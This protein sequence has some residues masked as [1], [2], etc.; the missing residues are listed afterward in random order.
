MYIYGGDGN[1][2]ALGTL[3]ELYPA[4]KWNN[5]IVNTPFSNIDFT[6]IKIYANLAKINNT[7]YVVLPDGTLKTVP[8]G[9]IA[10]SARIM[11]LDGDMTKTLRIDSA[12]IQFIRFDNGTIFQ[13]NANEI[14]PISSLAKY[15]SLGGNSTNTA[16]MPLKSLDTFHTGN[17]V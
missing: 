13:V 15:N 8:V 4:L 16:S 11:P 6:D 2:W 17:S 3:N 10:T 5:N 9:S 1:L 12:A 7:P 14:N